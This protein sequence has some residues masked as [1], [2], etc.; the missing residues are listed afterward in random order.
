MKYDYSDSYCTPTLLAFQENAGPFEDFVA[1]NK[2]KYTAATV[3]HNEMTTSA[4]PEQQDESVAVD[5]SGK[6]QQKVFQ[7]VENQHLLTRKNASITLIHVLHNV[8][9]VMVL[10]DIIDQAGRQSRLSI[11][12]RVSEILG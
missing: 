11:A 4:A 5:M 8:S 12:S 1:S 10:N 3:E 2:D 6:K 9:E 7:T